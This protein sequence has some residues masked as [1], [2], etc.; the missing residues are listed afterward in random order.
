M[1]YL[2]LLRSRQPA[3]PGTDKTDE[4]PPSHGETRREGT[5]KTDESPLLS[6]L[7]PP[8]GDISKSGAP[9]AL[10]RRGAVEAALDA[11]GETCP[12]IRREI[13]DR[14]QADPKALSFWTARTPKPDP[15]QGLYRKWLA[16]IEAPRAV[17]TLTDQ[18]AREAAAAGIV[19]RELA[20]G[21]VL[22][23]VRSP[24]GDLGPGAVGLLA[25]PRDKYRDF[26]PMAAVEALG[27]TH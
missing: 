9:L 26:S 5:D 13:L 20:R 23:L 11:L 18:Q 6:V 22:I 4:S 1:S 17:V 16:G 2:E 21:S 3:P 24:A 10:H 15:W 19:S 27:L 12:D 8:P 14:C 25:I 7:A